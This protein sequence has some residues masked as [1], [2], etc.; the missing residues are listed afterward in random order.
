[1][2]AYRRSARALAYRLRQEHL[3]R[4]RQ[5]LSRLLEAQRA[6]PKA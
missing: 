1:V 4:V 5:F 3:R 6:L 2:T